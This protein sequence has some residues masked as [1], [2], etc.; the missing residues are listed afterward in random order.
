MVSNQREKNLRKSLRFLGAQLGKGAK[1]A[2]KYK[3]HSVQE[4]FY[5]VFCLFSVFQT[6]SVDKIHKKLPIQNMGVI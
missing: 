5:A 1:I 3:R 6:F 4:V 2:A